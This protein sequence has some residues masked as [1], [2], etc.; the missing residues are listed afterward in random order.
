MENG[1]RILARL[2]WDAG[3]VLSV[4]DDGQPVPDSLAGQLFKSPVQSNSGL[5]VGMYQVARFAREQGYEV[6][7][8]SNQPGRVCFALTQAD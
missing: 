7:L 3:F 2:Q 8:S 1:L 4:C 6:A 5:G